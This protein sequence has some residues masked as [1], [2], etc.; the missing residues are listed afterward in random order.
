MGELLL[1]KL[2][3]RLNDGWL[4]RAFVDRR[5]DALG[6]FAR[7]SFTVEVLDQPDPR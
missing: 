2:H 5:Q 7:F 1:G 3:N 6:F 4:V